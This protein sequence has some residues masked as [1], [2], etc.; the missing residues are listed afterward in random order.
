MVRV[1]VKVMISV[2]G[3]DVPRIPD[4]T[5]H[6]EREG[7]IQY[8]ELYSRPAFL[9][10]LYIVGTNEFSTVCNYLLNKLYAH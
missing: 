8:T 4:T 3:R 5:D 9:T 2:Y 6:R 7:G 1:G 10:N